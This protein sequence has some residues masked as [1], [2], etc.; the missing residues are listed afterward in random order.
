MSARN[1]IPAAARLAEPVVS[2][3]PPTTLGGL[4]ARAAVVYGR[5]RG[6][7]R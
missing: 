7:H 4:Y 1:L 2:D 5:L 3:V 6:A